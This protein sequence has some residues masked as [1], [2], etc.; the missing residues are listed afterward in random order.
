MVY[1]FKDLFGRSGSA[2]ELLRS[3]PSGGPWVD[4][5]CDK[6]VEELI[7]KQQVSDLVSVYG[8]HAANICH[9][10]DNRIQLNVKWEKGKGWSC[11]TAKSVNEAFQQM[12]EQQ[13]MLATLKTDG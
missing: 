4:D 9:T 10:D 5:F 13:N 1:D 11:F 8:A 12:W 3:G 7:H 6:L 2:R